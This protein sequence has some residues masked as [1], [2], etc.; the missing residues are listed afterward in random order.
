MLSV[1]WAFAFSFSIFIAGI[2][3]VVRFKKINKV[4]YPFLFCIWLACFN[5][6]LNLLFY[7]THFNSSVNTNIYIL[8]EA[9]LITCLFKNF[10]VID[11]PKFLFKAIIILL[12]LVWSIENFVLG[13]ITQIGN[14]FRIVYSF[15][16]VLMSITYLNVLIATNRKLILKDSGFLLCLG[17][18]L[19]FTYKV[20]VYS[21][22]V[23]GLKSSPG[24]LLNVFAIMI[25]INLISNLIYA[26]AVLWMPRKLQYSQRY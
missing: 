18:I 26:L 6:L 13:R 14:Y 16:I 23:Y 19:Y 15:I 4:F 17:F 20:L 1:N 8:L 25:Y 3:A 2:I 5:D 7:N 22:W 21:F 10:G 12:V 11:K 24:F 9:I